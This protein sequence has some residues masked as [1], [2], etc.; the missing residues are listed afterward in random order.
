MPELADWTPYLALMVITFAATFTQSCTGFGS[1][2]I[3]MPLMPMF[4]DFKTAVPLTVLQALTVSVALMVQM[5]HE[6]RIKQIAFLTI[7]GLAGTVMG[8]MI[9]KYLNTSALETGLGILL[10]LFAG[11]SL[12][13]RIRQ[14]HFSPVWG[15]LPGFLTGAIA[16]ACSAGG[17]PTLIY[18]AIKD[19]DKEEL[20]ST[21]VGFF[22]INGV[23]VAA[24]HA[25]TG[26]TNPTVLSL[27]AICL[28]PVLLGTYLGIMMYGKIPTAIYRKILLVFLLVMGVLMTFS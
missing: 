14:F 16:S 26:M 1:A 4:I 20:K 8:L 7:G 15:L 6:F 17:P 25:I 10:V 23:V 19:W 22:F 21:L 3:T 2:L 24:G 5:R 28:L 9:L 27:Y 12:L 13:F 11:F 18:A